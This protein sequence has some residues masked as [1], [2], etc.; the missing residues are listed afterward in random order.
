MVLYYLLSTS[1]NTYKIIFT[2]TMLGIRYLQMNLKHFM[3]YK[4][5][6]TKSINIIN[7]KLINNILNCT[8]YNISY[9]TIYLL[10]FLSMI[11]NTISI[12]YFLLD[13]FVFSID[14]LFANCVYSMR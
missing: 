6:L 5:I 12:V 7:N 3:F 9:K 1:P 13:S 10:S 4:F 8:F 2:Y 11:A 14:Y